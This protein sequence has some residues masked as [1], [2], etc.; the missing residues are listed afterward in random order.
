MG[1]KVIRRVVN[2]VDPNL[3]KYADKRSI[4]QG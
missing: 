2:L 1:P 3:T 4:Y